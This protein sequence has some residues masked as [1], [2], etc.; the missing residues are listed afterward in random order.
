LKDGL[1][2]HIIAE[3]RNLEQSI[4][5][6]NFKYPNGPLSKDNMNKLTRVERLTEI[7]KREDES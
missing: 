3:L 1:Q 2:D 5:V 7:N 6:I 4:K